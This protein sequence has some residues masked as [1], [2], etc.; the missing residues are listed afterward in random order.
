MIAD[1]CHDLNIKVFWYSY[2]RFLT[3]WKWRQEAFPIY[4]ICN[5]VPIDMVSYPRRT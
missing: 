1:Y 2:N 3:P 4:I 5:H